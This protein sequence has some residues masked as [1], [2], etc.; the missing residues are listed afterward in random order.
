MKAAL[1]G[2]GYWGKIIERYIVAHGISSMI[3]G[4]KVVIGSCHFVFEDEG[5][6]IPEGIGQRFEGLPEE[7]SH[8]Y[9][10]ADGKLAAV[11]CIEHPLRDEAADVVAS[12]REALILREMQQ[13]RYDEIGEAL[14]LYIGTVK[15]RISRGRKKLRAFLLAGG[16]FSPPPPSKETGKEGRS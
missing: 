16:N 15:S 3:E 11:I 12:L 6:Q 10:T 9:M 2:Y 14:G 1:I 7:Y 4:K 5:C 8:L 13:L